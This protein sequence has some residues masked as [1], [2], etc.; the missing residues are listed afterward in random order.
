LSPATGNTDAVTLEQ[1]NGLVSAAGSTTASPGAV[2]NVSN[3]KTSVNWGVASQYC[4]GLSEGGFDDWGMP[5][6]DEITYAAARLKDTSGGMI[7]NDSYLWTRDRYEA[8]IQHW[9]VFKPSNGNWNNNNNNNT[10]N[11]RCVR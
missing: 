8:K 11:V 9:N 5:T 3:L 1:V 4:S 7:D 6:F 2:S 10:N